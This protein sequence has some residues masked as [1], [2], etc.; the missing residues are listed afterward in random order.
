MIAGATVRRRSVFRIAFLW[1]SRVF[2]GILN[3]GAANLH[4][5]AVRGFQFLERAVRA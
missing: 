5:D 3:P 1:Q 4:D 2:V